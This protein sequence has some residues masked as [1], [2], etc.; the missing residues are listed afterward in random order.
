M[1]RANIGRWQSLVKLLEDPEESIRLAV[2]EELQAEVKT[3]PLKPV[4]WQAL[5]DPELSVRRLA[6][7]LPIRLKFAEMQTL[8]GCLDAASMQNA[9]QRAES[10]IYLLIQSGQRGMR[11]ALGRAAESLVRDTYWLT[12]Q[13]SALKDLAL[14]KIHRAPLPD[15]CSRHFRKPPSLFWNGSSG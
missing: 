5:N 8:R 3:I 9:P 7:K 15:S 10:A 14:Q 11:T 2:V 4:V 13:G 12:L 1:G 6:C